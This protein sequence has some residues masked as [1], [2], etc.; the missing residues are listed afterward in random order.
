M[1]ALK[2]RLTV[3][4]LIQVLT[5]RGMTRLAPRLAQAHQRFY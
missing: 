5:R 1:Q 4:A 2:L 3:V